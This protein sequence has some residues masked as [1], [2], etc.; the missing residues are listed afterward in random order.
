MKR[1]HKRRI[2]TVRRRTVAVIK[3]LIDAL[4]VSES[5][6]AVIK[7]RKGENSR[8]EFEMAYQNS[9][10]L[11]DAAAWYDNW[12]SLG[13]LNLGS[14]E[15]AHVARTKNFRLRY[16]IY[17]GDSE[18]APHRT[19]L[20]TLM[21]GFGGPCDASHSQRRWVRYLCLRTMERSE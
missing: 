14:A 18:V 6:S 4:F 20:P 17:D 9:D 2:S 21:Y 8:S 5:D 11:P 7:L 16:E 19:D 13:S 1:E 15:L 10:P 12:G 3:P